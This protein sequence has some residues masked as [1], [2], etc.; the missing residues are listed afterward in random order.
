MVRRSTSPAATPWVIEDGIFPERAEPRWQQRPRGTTTV[1]FRVGLSSGAPGVLELPDD[2]ALCE[3]TAAIRE[4]DPVRLGARRLR[5]ADSEG[6]VFAPGEAT[7]VGEAAHNGALVSEAS[8]TLTSVPAVVFAIA[9]RLMPG[10]SRR[11][12]ACR[13]CCCCRIPATPPRP[14]H[15]AGRGPGERKS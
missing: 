12:A 8:A 6:R 5:A 4:S 7:T 13:S 1:R 14:P 11:A 10:C 15:G 2:L 9:A 3:L